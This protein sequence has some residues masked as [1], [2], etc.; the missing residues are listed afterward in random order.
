MWSK[1][2][3]GCRR[4]GLRRFSRLVGLWRTKL[5]MSL[6]IGPTERVSA[7]A[8]TL[9]E[10]DR[11]RNGFK[12][13]RS[14]GRVVARRRSSCPSAAAGPLQPSSPT[15]P[16]WSAGAFII[17]GAGPTPRAPAADCGFHGALGGQPRRTMWGVVLNVGELSCPHLL[18]QLYWS[19]SGSQFIC[20]TWESTL[21]LS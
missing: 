3:R 19:G 21:K 2:G 9:A 12:R 7:L 6:L 14:F 17:P 8:A 10:P 20:S 16:M 5:T 18:E 1:V 13:L 4:W 15:P 11:F